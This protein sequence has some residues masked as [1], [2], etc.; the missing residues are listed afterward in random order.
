MIR[1]TLQ[2]IADNYVQAKSEPFAGHPVANYIRHNAKDNIRQAIPIPGLEFG[3]GVG[4]SGNWARVPWIGIYDPV[5]TTSAQRGYYLVY[6]F[7]ADMKHVYLSL[8]QGATEVAQELGQ[9]NAATEEL[10]RR[11]LRV[12]SRLSD[13]EAYFRLDEI[14]LASTGRYPRDYEAGHAFGRAYRADNLPDEE[15]LQDDLR[16]LLRIYRTL[17]L[18]G[19]VSEIPEGE[20]PSA[21]G[22]KATITEK[23]QYR[24]HRSLDRS[25]DASRKVKAIQG[26]TCKG[27]EFEFEAVYG[28]IGKNYIEAHHLIP[29][30][31]LKEGEEVP[32]DPKDDFAVLCANC[33]RMVHRTNPPMPI[34]DLRALIRKYKDR[35]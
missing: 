6:L 20:P 2:Y 32:M 29:V 25:G 13:V 34:D 26:Y 5:V 3:S 9:T 8:N 1:E 23:R 12:R 17:I 28:E 18:R 7:A 14:D 24:V 27:C 19:G 31:S 15:T 16:R 33:H 11:A 35:G 10:A 21:K 22:K 4:T 30:S